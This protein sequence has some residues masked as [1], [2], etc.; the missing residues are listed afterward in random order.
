MEDRLSKAVNDIDQAM[1]IKYNTIVYELQ[2]QGRKILIMSLG[3]AFF[4]IPLFPMDVLPNPKIY[5]YSHSRG[6]P[7]LREKLT[8]YFLSRY[9]IPINYE[10]EILI[11][12]GSKA[13]IHFAFMAIL[14]PGDEVIIPEPA[15]VSYPEQVKLCH[16]KPVQVP[17]DKSIYEYENYIT[18]KT[19]AI[20]IC[21]P[22]NPTGHVYNEKEL[23]Y[24]LELAE[25]NKIWLLSDEAYSEFVDDDTFI[26]PGKIDRDKK[27][28]IIFNSISKNYGISGWRLGY[29]IASESVINNILKINQHLI[30]C[31]A[32]ILELYVER[33]FYDILEIT[34]PQIK[35]LIKKRKETA[36]YM[37]RIGLKYMEGSGTFYFFIS[38]SPSGLTSE[39]FA[40]QLLFEESISVVP[41]I[42]YGH[43][44]DKFIRVS[45]G[46]ATLDENRYALDK[47]KQ[48]ID[49][50]TTVPA[51][52]NNDVLVIAGGIWQRPLIGFLKK[53]GHK[54]TVVDPYLYSEGVQIADR[55]IKLDVRNT[56]AI[57]N[58]IKNSKFEFIATDQSDISVN[59]VALLSERLNLLSNPYSVTNR[60][61][62]KYE[63][64][65]LSKK[66]NINIPDYSKISNIVEL[67]EFI[68]EY[69]MPVII[70]PADSQSSRGVSKI[71]EENISSLEKYFIESLKFANCGYIIAEKFIEGTEVTVEGFAS[72]YRHRTLAISRKKHFRTAIASSLEYPADI[73]ERIY[74]KIESFND[75]FVENSGL[76]FGITHSEYIIERTSGEPYL[77]EI[78]CRGGGSLIS[79]DIINWVSGNDVYEMYYQNLKGG[80]TD[81]KRLEV[82]KRNAILQFFEFRPGTVKKINGVD[83]AKQIKGVLELKLAFKPGDFLKPAEDDRSRQGFVIIFADSKKELDSILARVMEKIEIEY[84]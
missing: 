20:I 55:H 36:T 4:D 53:K 77:I 50:T 32:T 66:L 9:D 31:P 81:V 43:S 15:W 10:K 11:T 67:R 72:A 35:Q 26:S 21:N 49:K 59:T 64:R 5:H 70:K 63:M 74:S 13:A 16:A 56:E 37:D 65:N 52:G 30:T 82:K 73:E 17:Y 34:Q 23:I 25:R 45:I 51:S 79:S 42:G 62:N 69:G 71:T 76:Q 28:T 12:A 75:L 78:A 41:G 46:T 6:I 1:S 18:G 24:L 57:F 7:E 44:C 83:E 80:I 47:I 40:T 19:K 3:E 60:F 2:R 58:E 84:E 61:V 68:R 14:N 27:N 48:L 22:H 38:I 8:E 33:Y 54:V 29:V 39:E